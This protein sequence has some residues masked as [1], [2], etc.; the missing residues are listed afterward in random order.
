MFTRFERR[1][2][3]WK[4]ICNGHHTQRSRITIKLTICLLRRYGSYECNKSI[5]LHVAKNLHIS[6]NVYAISSLDQK[7]NKITERS[8]TSGKQ[9]DKSC[10]WT[11]LSIM[12]FVADAISLPT[13]SNNYYKTIVETLMLSMHGCSMRG[14]M[15][16]DIVRIMR[17]WIPKKYIVSREHNRGQTYTNQIGTNC[18]NSN[19]FWRFIR[20][21]RFNR[22]DGLFVACFIR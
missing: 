17:F 9:N 2:V 15:M 20:F 22:F 21:V 10:I 13:K 18:Q 4:C 14:V 3:A 1:K 19:E 12:H 6:D 16:S 11:L 5:V 7:V 8:L